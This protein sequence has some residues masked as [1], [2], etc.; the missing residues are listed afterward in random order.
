[1]F[2]GGDSQDNAQMEEG[3]EQVN[4]TVECSEDITPVIASEKDDKVPRESQLKD[5]EEDN[6]LEGESP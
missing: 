5:S 6:I 2:T 1:M 3:R 4:E